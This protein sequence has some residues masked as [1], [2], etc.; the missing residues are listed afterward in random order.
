VL[1]NINALG[2]ENEEISIELKYTVRIEDESVNGFKSAVY[3]T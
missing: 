2:A 1:Y 3:I